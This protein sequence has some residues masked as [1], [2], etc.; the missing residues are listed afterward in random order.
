MSTVELET[1]E[2]ETAATWLIN[3][4]GA[5]GSIRQEAVRGHMKVVLTPQ[6]RAVN[7]TNAKPELDP[8]TNGTFTCLSDSGPAS[9]NHLTDSE[10]E[11]LL[12]DHWKRAQRRLNEITSEAALNR[13]LEV[14]ANSN[15]G[16]KRVEMIRDR[17][18]ELNPSRS[19]PSTSRT[20]TPQPEGTATPSEFLPQPQRT[21][22]NELASQLMANS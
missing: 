12:S 16:A 11:G 6:D 19:F 17:I 20:L 7:Q 22:F 4:V 2:N 13:V 1:W 9:P 18:L 3:K 14:A 8:F 10:I 15:A 5:D 21:N